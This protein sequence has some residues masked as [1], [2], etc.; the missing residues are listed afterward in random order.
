MEETS[1]LNNELP[2]DKIEIDE[3]KKL[4]PNI[5][6]RNPGI[7]L[8]RILGMIDIIT[9]HITINGKLYEKYKK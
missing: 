8:L 5:K 6:I 2:N 4:D 1:R 9:Y 7:D 3:S